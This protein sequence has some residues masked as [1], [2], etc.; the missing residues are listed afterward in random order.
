MLLIMITNYRIATQVADRS[1]ERCPTSSHQSGAS[2]ASRRGNLK[3][4]VSR[5][6]MNQNGLNLSLS[7]MFLIYKI[8]LFMFQRNLCIR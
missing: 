2:E 7:A 1:K 3:T 8:F 4:S 6:G 5:F